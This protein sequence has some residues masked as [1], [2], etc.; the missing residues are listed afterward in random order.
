MQSPTIS[1]ITSHG[2]GRVCPLRYVYGAN[3][4]A[5]APVR[6]A[7]T[8]YVVGGLYGNLQALDS[9]EAMANAE[10]QPAT[11]C[12]NGDF[13]WFNISDENFAEINRRVLSHDAIL[14][15]VE[16]EFDAPTHEAGCGC[17]YP[18][19]VGGD[20]VERSNRIHARLRATATRHPE[21]RSQLSR[22]PM[23][24][25]YT[26]AQCRVGVV[27]GDAESL[28]GWRFDTHEMN[29]PQAWPWLQQMFDAA[30]VDVF[31][32]THTCLPALRGLEKTSGTTGWIANNGAAGM[33]NFTGDPRGL[34]TRIGIAP[35]P[36]ETLR[37]VC[38]AGAYLSLLP[39]RFDATRWQADFVRQW[40]T[41]SDA[42]VSYFRRISEGPAFEVGRAL[43]SP[44]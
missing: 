22:L 34:V 32:S 8:L 5:T 36:H 35:S 31:T 28:A 33:P 1:G 43:R 26:V 38:V 42:W 9:L 17:A 25:R 7:Q 20:V 12:F 15:N 21:I 4:I 44:L 2:A 19:S 14:G 16:A 37:E 3:T 29:A 18:P 40:P 11:L 41:G 39:V 10:A 27:H 13:N 23:V 30:A 24:A 6:T